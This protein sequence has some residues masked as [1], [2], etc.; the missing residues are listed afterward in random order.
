LPQ[1]GRGSAGHKEDKKKFLGSP[2]RKGFLEIRRPFRQNMGV[3]R[4]G[5]DTKR[6]KM[7]KKSNRGKEQFRNSEFRGANQYWVKKDQ[8]KRP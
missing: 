2:E 6:N 8:G 3:T 1:E 4:K 7:T 5:R